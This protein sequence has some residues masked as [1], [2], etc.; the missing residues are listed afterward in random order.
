MAREVG[1]AGVGVGGHMVQAQ[2]PGRDLECPE[3]RGSWGS[4]GWASSCGGALSACRK[5]PPQC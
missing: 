2:R 1:E 5:Q 4:L 3:M